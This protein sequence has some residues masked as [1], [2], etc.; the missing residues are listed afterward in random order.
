LPKYFFAIL[1]S[2]SITAFSQTEEQFE[3]TEIEFIGNKNISEDALRNVIFSKESPGWLSQFLNSFSGFGEEATYFDSLQIFNDLKQLQNFYYDN[4]Y[5]QAGFSYKY[6]LDTANN[7]AKLIYEI[8]END[9]AFFRKLEVTGLENI[10]WQIADEVNELIKIDTSEIYSAAEVSRI[11]SQIMRLALDFGHMLITSD[12]P[13]IRVDTLVDKVDVYMNFDTGDRYRVSEVRINKSGPGAD[14]VSDELLDRIANIDSNDYYSFY[15][16]Q[17]SQV[18]LYRT[19]LFSSVLISGVV[20]DTNKNY[21][22]IA[23]NA[24][25]GLMN[26]LSPELV[27][28][29]EDNAFNLGVGLSYSRKNFLG[30][31]RKLTLSV[32][33]AAQDISQLISNPSLSDTNIYGYVDLR[34]IIEQPF[35]FGRSINTKLE[36]YYTLQ[37]RR[38]EYNATLLGGKLSFDIELPRFTYITS[39]I[40]GLNVER[41]SYVFSYDYTYDVLFKYYRNQAPELPVEFVDS[42]ITQFLT[43]DSDLTSQKTISIL[44][45]DISVNKANSLLFPTRGYTLSLLLEDG[46]SLS[47][48]ANKIAG[49]A[50][51]NPLYFKA[52]FTGTFYFPIYDSPEDAFGMKFRLGTIQTYQGDQFEIPFNQRF[53]AGGSNSNRGWKTRE[54][55]PPQNQG[56]LSANPTPDELESVLLRNLIPGG[57]FIMEGSIETRNRITG[58]LGSALFLDYGNVWNHPS[59]FRLDNIAVAAGFGLRYYSDFAPFRIDFGFKVYDPDDPRSF[60]KKSLFSE[61]F[62]FHFGIGEA[63]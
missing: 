53:Y 2:I 34:G 55:V 41:S 48:L 60:F 35:L 63:F 9:P 24:D 17:R 31:A 50:F 15:E 26:E 1:L 51:E 62:E 54:L 32:S 59:D 23:I 36:T 3:L 18:R 8:N 13:E 52:L 19:N 38:S 58:K 43:P 45:A 49:D 22:P 46:N 57:F 30:D 14:E 27:I 5:F 7:T 4:G 37:K 10:A 56:E 29:N 61:T 39:L 44:N 42:L 12:P 25:V 11:R 20:A 47:Y 33:T 16:L 40:L 21:V 6:Q 28:N